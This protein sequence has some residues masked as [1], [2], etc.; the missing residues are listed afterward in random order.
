MSKITK[1]PQ[2]G[3][4]N[5]APDTPESSSQPDGT[6]AD[7]P[8]GETQAQ[9][10]GPHS[11]NPATA[12]KTSAPVSSQTSESRQRQINPSAPTQGTEIDHAIT[13][14]S[15]LSDTF[16]EA[17]DPHGRGNLPIQEMTI[18]SG[19]SQQENFFGNPSNERKRPG[20]SGGDFR[21]K[22]EDEVA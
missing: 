16:G 18:Q 22:D 15:S 13:K 17:G 5:E 19:K 14:G 7:A 20:D 9:P 6:A 3:T 12:G 2:F 8:R 10:S 21:R 1:S 4:T 11:G